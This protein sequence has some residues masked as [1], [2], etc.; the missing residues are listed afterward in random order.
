MR[1]RGPGR[2]PTLA[3]STSSSLQLPS[4]LR[5]P[6]SSLLKSA[7]SVEEAAHAT[8][9]G[10]RTSRSIDEQLDRAERTGSLL[11]RLLGHPQDTPAMTRQHEDSSPAGQVIQAKASS[12]RTPQAQESEEIPEATERGSSGRTPVAPVQRMILKA[13]GSTP[14][15]SFPAVKA[16]V[17][18]KG[19]L[20]NQA[21][22]LQLQKIFRDPNETLS[23]DDA[24]AKV[25]GDDEMK[26][27][28]NEMH[29]EAE[30]LA[31]RGRGPGSSK[32]EM[33][34][35]EAK[36]DDHSEEKDDAAT[37]SDDTI[38]S[39]FAR[40]L[41]P[42][43]QLDDVKRA[44]VADYD[45]QAIREALP[46]LKQLGEK[47]IAS[48]FDTTRRLFELLGNQ[49]T[50]RGDWNTAEQASKG[51]PKLIRDIQQNA[52]SGRD[53]IYRIGINRVAHGFTIVVRNNSAE[54]IQGFAGPSGESLAE[55]LD[56]PG[57]FDIEE[58]CQLLGDL[59]QAG[60]TEAF[61]A[62]NKLFN[63][64][65]D[66]ER[67]SATDHEKLAAARAN[68][69]LTEAHKDEQD[70]PGYRLF[71]RDLGQDVF[72][73]QRRDLYSPQE[74]EARIRQ[75]ITDGLKALGSKRR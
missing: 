69:A 16:Q 22:E 58:I 52:Q 71:Y 20:L 19:I 42:R 8:R 37:A 67:V 49:T 9:N 33:E 62:Q 3:P 35:P 63:G 23:L 74:L 24:L 26:V 4:S 65:I 56:R 31:G 57:S 11:E 2:L 48:C 61:D 7:A 13:D 27:T 60:T 73:L 46:F 25:S 68:P 32:M 38:R 72:Q 6:P 45:A 34:D 50:Q 15:A 36:D 28:A 54:L 66:I 41:P 30:P 14:Y 47:E 12:A 29:V 64:S 21:Q 44:L 43:G 55:N 39:I 18:K 17:T 70:T 59:L 51:M 40:Y 75:K 5:P 53:V 10:P 1:S